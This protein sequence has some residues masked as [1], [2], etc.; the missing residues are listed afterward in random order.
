MS[1]RWFVLVA[2]AGAVGCG[3]V[4]RRASMTPADEWG[5]VPVALR[6]TFG[7]NLLDFRFKVVDAKKAR[8]LFDRRIKPYL[9]DRASHE[10]LGMPEDSKL[11]ALRAGLRNPPIAGKLY[12]VLF[13]NARGTVHRGS[14]VDV[15]LGD[16][17]LENVRV[18]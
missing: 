11:G 2:L 3:N 4:G 7:G 8:P 9:V 5:I 12:F 6:P 18:E 16:C 10:A 17:K 1:A 13:A 14:R 15:V